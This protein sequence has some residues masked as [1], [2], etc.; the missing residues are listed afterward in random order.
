MGKESGKISFS[1]APQE[2]A[3]KREFLNNTKTLFFSLRLAGLMICLVVWG[4]A[5]GLGDL[6]VV[7]LL[8][9][10]GAVSYFWYLC[11][12]NTACFSKR[13]NRL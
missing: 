5:P 7:E 9:V 12:Y 8:E 6:V 2:R 10:S 11:G 3:S 4:R 13:Y 1:I